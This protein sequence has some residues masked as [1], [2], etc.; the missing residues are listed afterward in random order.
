MAKIALVYYSSTG[1][2]HQMAA[3]VAE[4]AR[5]VGAEVRLRAAKDDAVSGS[6]STAPR[7][8]VA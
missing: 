8:D 2:T 4:G 6:D 3:A 7:C 5:S 1:H